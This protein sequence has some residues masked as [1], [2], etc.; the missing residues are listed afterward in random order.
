MM[1]SEP[2]LGIEPANILG[3]GACEQFDILR[4][5][6][7]VTAKHIGRPLI[8]GG[9][10]EPYFAA[11]RLP[12]ADQRAH[13]RRFARAAGADHTEPVAGLER[14]GHIL[15][16]HS[17]FAG[18]GDADG[19][20][21]KAA[22][23]VLQQRL[24]G[25][26][27]Q[28]FEQPVEAMPALPRGHEA[29]P[30][31]DREIDRRQ[32]PRAQDRAGDDNAGGRFLMDH[33]IGAD[34][35]DRRLQGHA[36]DLG[37]GAETAGDVAGVLIAGEIFLVGLAPAPVEA[38]GHPHCDQHF[39]VAPA[40]GG[41]IVAPRCQTQSFPRRPARHELGHDGEGD[42]NDRADQRG[43]ADHHMEGKADRQIERQPWQV[44]ERAWPHAGEERAN[45]V[46]IAQRLQ[47]LV[48]SADRQRQAY[49]GIEHPAVE[50][51][52]ER[53][54]DPAQDSDPDQVESALGHVQ[55]AGE[56]GEADQGR[57]AAA[58]QHPVVHLQHEQRAGQ[59]QQVDHAAHDADADEGAA[60]GA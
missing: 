60:A 35:E 7:D 27:G 41:Q 45:I 11:E 5:I 29:L 17:L 55:S 40:G 38:P 30:V 3:D 8:E 2:R 43:Q 16:H 39:G 6:A 26:R 14:E 20:E 24:R 47:A 13:Q 32:R 9:A 59:I 48:A 28:R 36:Q 49:N 52:I 54:A 1:A 18:R 53:G 15:H 56:N 34:G 46:E 42:Q 25:S 37:D 21:R 4:Q 50:R 23:R 22:R 12:D 51:F 31:R 44:E 19:L 57:H 10:I 33:Q 58:R